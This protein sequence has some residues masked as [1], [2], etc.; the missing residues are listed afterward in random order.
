MIIFSISSRL[1]LLGSFTILEDESLR[2][3]VAR[4]IEALNSE[5]VNLQS[6]TTDYSIWDDI[7]AFVNGEKPGF[8]EENFSD[9]S[10]KNL[11]I[12]LAFI[13]NCAGKLLFQKSDLPLGSP[14]DSLPANIIHALDQSRL[15]ACNEDPTAALSGVMVVDDIPLLVS[16]HSIFKSD[17]SGPSNGTL[18][19]VRNI[20]QDEIQLLSTTTNLTLSISNG[21]AEKL[22]PGEEIQI[23]PLN[24]TNISGFGLVKALTG[25]PVLALRVDKPRDIF[26]GGR[27]P[28]NISSG[29]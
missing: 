24:D 14:Y 25:E 4:A 13:R 5:K 12:N 18:V 16:I 2:R 28:C 15:A 27:R 19:F 23:R 26:R 1:I 11:R 22:S 6:S 10:T 21:T 29:P 9:T 17:S 7:Y 3:D 8:T 20:N